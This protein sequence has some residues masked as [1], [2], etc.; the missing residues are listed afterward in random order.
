MNDKIESYVMTAANR[1]VHLMPI[2]VMVSEAFAGGQYVEEI[3]KKYIGGCHYDFDISRLIWDGETLIHHWGVW[4][5]AI[6]VESVLLKSAGIGAV[7]T[8]EPYRK[9]GFMGRA[10]QASFEAMAHNGYDIS[11]LRGRHYRKFG[12]RRAWNY[13]TTK[14]DPATSPPEEIPAYEL[15]RPYQPLGPAHMDAINALYNRAYAGYSGSCVRPTYPMLEDGEMKAF[16]WF[17]EGE[18]LEGYVRAVPAQENKV[19]QCLEAAGDP[20]QGLAVLGDFFHEGGYEQLHFFTMP[21]LHPILQIVRRGACTLEDRYFHH[22]GWLVKIVNLTSTLEK[23]SSL[24]EK[25]LVKS[26]LAS[27]RGILNLDAGEQKAALVIDN[28]HVDVAV[29]HGGEHAVHGGPAI[30]R[31]LIGSDEPAE[32]IRQEGVTLTGMAGELVE[33]LFPNLHPMMSHWDEF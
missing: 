9:Q 13:V 22:T 8:L 25:R 1:D 31:L 5:Y 29:F 20:E 18:E 23:L 24:F 21:A 12:Y 11:I 19:L 26:H 32:I 2:S 4:G 16:G 17:S 3:S 15:K 14:L 7:V 27:W 6:R 10:A 33:V 28:G 30:G